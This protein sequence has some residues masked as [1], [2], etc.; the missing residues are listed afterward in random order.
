M[1]Y[2]SI[3]LLL[4]SLISINTIGCYYDNEEELY[5][6]VSSCDTAAVSYS[7]KLL[8]IIE[9]QC[10]GCHSAAAY[11]AAGGGYNLEGYTNVK[12]SVDD[13]TF[14]PAINQTGNFPMPKGGNKLDNC[15]IAQFQ[16]WINAGAP[17]N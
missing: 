3:L 12:A 17:N 15:T 2:L 13:N 7:T 8:P 5:P 11:Q 4:L 16:A 1:K 14:L 10:I 6:E 9:D